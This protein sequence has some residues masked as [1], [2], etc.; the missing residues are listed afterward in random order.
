M[1]IGKFQSKMRALFFLFLMVYSFTCYAFNKETIQ[2][3]V[4][5]GKTL[6]MDHYLGKSDSVSQ[7]GCIIFVFGGGFSSGE[8]DSKE[9]LSYFEWLN[10]NG[11]DV[12]SIDYRLGMSKEYDS[13]GWKKGV[14]GMVGRFTSAIHWACDDMISA[15]LY[16]LEHSKQWNIDVNN[17]VACGSSAG[18]ITCLTVENMICN[19]KTSLPRMF[20][21]SAV[22]SFAGAIYSTHSHPKW[23]NKPCPILFFH[24][25]SD[26]RVPYKRAAL[27]GKGLWGSSYI[28]KQLEKMNS[29]YYFYDAIY[30]THSMA[31]SPM[32]GNHTEIIE[33]LNFV[34]A[35]TK[36]IRIHKIVK[37]NSI[38]KRKTHFSPLI[39]VSQKG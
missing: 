33:F 1:L 10:A 28:V 24:G 11:Y 26:R 9:Y 16:I 32:N 2:F 19:E 5:E 27:F 34:S 17:I 20:N 3:S 31:I 23:N 36:N 18:A 22:I 38:P 39:Y 13:Y 29:P 14:M 37:D 35:K 25:N 15:T 7:K 4:K 12:A 21:Y 30:Q 6:Y 8:R